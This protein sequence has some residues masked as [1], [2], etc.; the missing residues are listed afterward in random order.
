[1]AHIMPLLEEALRP[2]RTG[3]VLRLGFTWGFPSQWAH[4]AMEEFTEATGVQ[5]QPI[6]RDEPLAGLDHGDA[7]IALLRGQVSTSRMRRFTLL[8]ER[9][10][11]AAAAGSRYSRL[12]SIAW[13]DIAALPL[14]VN[15]VSGTTKAEDWPDAERPMVAATCTNFD[16]W[17]EAVAADWGVGCVPESIA[18]RHT[19]PS[20][21]FIPVEGAPEIPMHLVF[22][23]NGAHPLVPTFVSIAGA[24]TKRLRE[25]DDA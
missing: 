14:V 6:R 19:H 23:R 11:M 13:R 16:E 8:T 3:E 2:D 5:V 1:M 20:V 21:V 15:T 17:L 9:R 24:V 10:V 18:H 25:G 12:T 4:E 22:P 7:D